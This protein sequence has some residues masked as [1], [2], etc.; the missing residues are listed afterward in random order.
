MGCVSAQI[1]EA[2]DQL[3]VL[4]A[5]WLYLLVRRLHTVV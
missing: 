2:E 4:L 1:N 3:R 5:P